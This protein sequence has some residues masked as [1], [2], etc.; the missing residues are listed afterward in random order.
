MATAGQIQ[1]DASA[2]GGIRRADGTTFGLDRAQ[3]LTLT[4]SLLA[5]NALLSKIFSGIARDGLIY[6][7]LNTF[8]VSVIVWGGLYLGLK[9]ARS[10]EPEPLT[11]TDKAVTVA[12]IVACF[13]PL[14]P[15]TWPVMSA[16]A[17]YF[18]WASRQRAQTHMGWVM[19]AVTVPMFWSKQL[20]SVF[21][22]FFLAIDASIVA[23]I[24]GTTRVSNV[25][26]MPN[27]AGYMQIAAPC[28]SMAN[29]SLALCCWVLFT[30]A[31]DTRWKPGNT[32]WCALACLAVMS[33][34]IFRISLIGYFPQHFDLLHGPIGSSAA[35][36]A[37]LIVVVL[38]CNYGVG[39]GKSASV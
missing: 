11:A 27:G 7:I 9:F 13:L 12:A 26:A 8:E 4:F 10:V 35:S 30:Q 39:R 1:G 28:S 24:T 18:I 6:S 14:S 17:I 23:S 25:V 15:L 3:V 31:T 34:N 21:S 38:I 5:A 20:F 19:L 32:L 2:V 29:V 33:I 22:N 16:T 36:W 37:S